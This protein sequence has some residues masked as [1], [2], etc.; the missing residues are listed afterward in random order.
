MVSMKRLFQ[1]VLGI[2]GSAI[3]VLPVAANTQYKQ[4]EVIQSEELMWGYLNPLRGD[5]SPRAADLWGDRTKN[6]ATGMLVGFKKGFSSPPH[7]HNITY[8]GVVIEGLMHNDDPGAEKMWLPAGSYWTQ[9]A[10]ENH[11]TAANGDT[12]LIF[13]EIN[14]G[15]YLVKPTNQQ[16][17]DGERPINVHA[18]NVVWLDETESVLLDGGNIDIAYLWE[19]RHPKP[20]AG[21]LLKLGAGFT[22]QISI[23][24]SEFRAVV[25]R[26]DVSYKSDETS[27]TL[28]LLQSSYFRSTGAFKHELKANEDSTIYVRT[29][30]KLKVESNN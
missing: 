21:Y 6:I 25:V 17:D 13:L 23:T 16:F 3:L 27:E 2:A 10:G 28:P 19:T 5:K 20:V 29:N 4:S 22:G 7:I 24:A 8:R 1:S 15:P 26:G 12:N 11:I 14:S 18:S 9:P 30:G